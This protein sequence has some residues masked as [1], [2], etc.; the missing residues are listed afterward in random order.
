[1]APNTVGQA[2]IE[3]VPDLTGFHKKAT[4]EIR[5]MPEITA[6]VKMVPDVDQFRKDTIRETKAATADLEVAVKVVPDVRT[7]RRDLKVALN[8]GPTPTVD[9]DVSADT[10]KFTREIRRVTAKSPPVKVGVDA[11]T[12]AARTKI[13]AVS[14]PRKTTLNVDA[15]TGAATVQIG[16]LGAMTTAAGVAAHFAGGAFRSMGASAVAA[17]VGGAASIALIG[18]AIVGII[19]L[20][21]IAA[22]AIGILGVGLIGLGVAAVPALGAIALG[23]EGIKNAA[24]EA[25]AGF[26]ALKSSMSTALEETMRPGFAALGSLLQEIIPQAQNVGRAFGEVFTGISTL[27][28]DDLMGEIRTMMDGMAV[29]IRALQPGLE[30]MIVGFMNLGAVF[31]QN[32]Q[33]V[34]EGLGAMLGHLGA[35]FDRLESMGTLQALF[36]ALG[37]VLASTGAL[38]GGLV[39]GLALAG[40]VMA[41][42]LAPLLDS[43]TA[44]LPGLGLALGAVGN[45]LSQVLIALMPI[46]GPL[47]DLLIQIAPVLATALVPVANALVGIVTMLAPM[48]GQYVEILAPVLSAILLMVGD[49]LVAVMPM[50]QVF[51]D[52]MGQMAPIFVQ[53]VGHIA[54][55]L[56]MLAPVLTSLISTIAPVIPVLAQAFLDVVEALMPLMPALAQLAIDLMPVLGFVVENVV[57]PAIRFLAWFIIPFLVVAAEGVIRVIG[58]VIGVLVRVKDWLVTAGHAVLDFGEW[59][60][61]MARAVWDKGGEALQWFR[62]LPGKIQGYLADAGSWLVDTGRNLIDGLVSGI[63]SAGGAVKDAILALVPDAIEGPIK[64]ALG[65][66]SP[67]RLMMEVGTYVGQGLAQGMESTIPEVQATGTALAAAADP[68]TPAGASAPTA[69]PEIPNVTPTVAADPNVDVTGMAEAVNAALT[70]VAAPAWENYGA[71]VQGVQAGVLAPATAT[72]ASA[73]SAM[74]GSMGASLG[75]ANA[76]V[77][78]TGNVMASTVQGQV[79]P[80]LGVANASVRNTGA[81]M[82]SIT[83]G[84]MI[85]AW[86]NA[87]NQIRAVQVGPMETA[88]RETRNSVQYTANTFG[89]AA[90][91]ISVQWGR[92]REGT[93]A[94]VRWSIQNVFND[95]V[96]GSWNSVSELLGTKKMGS[97]PLRFATGGVLPGYT[98]GRDVHRFVS[99]TGGGLELSGGEAIMRPEWTAAVGGPRAVESMN[100]AAR[101]GRLSDLRA[102]Y[103]HPSTDKDRFS[104]GGIFPVQSFAGGGIVE[105]L[106]W[107]MR[108]KFPMLKLTS[109]LRFTDNGYH[110]RGAAGDFSNGYDSTP[111]MRAAAQW[112]FQNYR[113]QTV[114][115]IHAPSPFNIGSGRHVGDGYG[116]YGAGTMGQH[117]NHV[118]WAANSPVTLEGSGPV[119]EGFV[120]GGDPVM[121]MGQMVAEQTAPIWKK[122]ADKVAATNFPGMTQPIPKGYLDSFKGAADK[123]TEALA[124]AMSTFADPGGGG[125]ERWRP[126]VETLLKRYG[127]SLSNTDLTLR[128]M[129]QESG[130]NPRAINNWDINAKNG[131]PSKGLMQVIDP[132][133]RAHRDPAL[134][135]DIWDPM[136]NVA[137]SM[138][139]AMSRYGSLAAAYNRPGG[140]DAGGWLDP[141]ISTIYNGFVKPEAILSPAESERFVN[142]ADAFLDHN[143]AGGSFVGQHVENQYVM[144]PDEV[145]AKSRR[146]VRRAMKEAGIRG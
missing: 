38:V 19:G 58:Q 55:L 47:S 7:F 112:I 4:R 136:A 2:R 28:R 20:V 33:A 125:V 22:G 11:D 132:T 107:V 101:S 21:G 67:S 138:R 68:S 73:V 3:L 126:L 133:F 110:S 72:A 17:G 146:G 41:P 35:V 98:P 54:N 5:Q 82:A 70:G 24:G 119:P 45:A 109:G 131:V 86:S 141:G 115:L 142:I 6:Q 18:L 25:K 113:R 48:L 79:V 12:V 57:I 135:P 127:H 104:D 8:N 56:V 116:F 90:D 64:K 88:F 100:A 44:V 37:P 13:A 80:A 78:N 53:I 10:T 81:V 59:I 63:K 117:R 75:Q 52:L 42:V 91:T 144:D 102:A 60:G 30:T 105:S 9:V 16:V 123:K 87:G 50:V 93:A 140:Y 129:N 145:Q 89:P 94:P 96:V 76:S 114:E 51:L 134:S 34:G 124:N 71:T 66:Q 106:A 77:V 121:S 43:M 32:A 31:A 120:A 14:R 143:M 27:L 49:V 92:L 130:G 108:N 84:Q 128:R 62:D 26:D 139:Y 99:P 111:E 15:D 39:E 137:A 103:R 97:Y 85:P 40:Q 95:G 46:F 74:V 1:M 122:V 61:R 65:I 36:Q 69:S 29:F 23:F 118:H 83:A